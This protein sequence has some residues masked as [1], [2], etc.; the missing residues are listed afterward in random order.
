VERVLDHLYGTADFGAALIAAG[1][2]PALIG[3]SSVE[4]EE[5]LPSPQN[6]SETIFGR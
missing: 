6:A 4:P 2:A 1:G 3:I 5:S